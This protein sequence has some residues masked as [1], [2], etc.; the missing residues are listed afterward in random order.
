MKADTHVWTAHNGPSNETP[1]RRLPP[2]HSAAGCS[3]REK[4]NPRPGPV[5]TASTGRGGGGLAET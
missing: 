4:Q 3:I 5:S 1:Q 2:P